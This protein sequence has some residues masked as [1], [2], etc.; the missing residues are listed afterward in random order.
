MQSCIVVRLPINPL[1]NESLLMKRSQ[2]LSNIPDH[3]KSL[4][5]C[6]QCVLQNRAGAGIF[7]CGFLVHV[8][9]KPPHSDTLP[10]ARF[11]AK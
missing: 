2:F 11:R 9:G 4:H 3:G 1:K 8:V 6:L 10:A 5:Y 7:L